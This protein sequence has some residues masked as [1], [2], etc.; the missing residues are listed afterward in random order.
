MTVPSSRHRNVATGLF[1]LFVVAL[2]PPV[3][4]L[5]SRGPLV[6][7]I[8]PLYLWFVTSGTF[9][10]LVLVWAAHRDA[11]ALTEEQIPPEVARVDAV[12]DRLHH[13]LVL[14][15][16]LTGTGHDVNPRTTYR[17]RREAILPATA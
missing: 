9:G 10:A 15:Q 16:I 1:V 3:V 11:F 12:G 4:N 7:G 6:L 14:V 8:A 2:N 17:K 13:R 5:V